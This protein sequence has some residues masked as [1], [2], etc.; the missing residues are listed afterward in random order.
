MSWLDL[1]SPRESSELKELKD[2]DEESLVASDILKSIKTSSIVTGNKRV[3]EEVNKVLKSGGTD[4]EK[5]KVI[6]NYL[7]QVKDITSLTYISSFR[8]EALKRLPYTSLKVNRDNN[9]IAKSNSALTKQ[10]ELQ[11]KKR[12]SFLNQLKYSPTQETGDQGYIKRGQG[13]TIGALG[14]AVAGA[15]KG[16]PIAGASIGGAIGSGAEIIDDVF[17]SKEGKSNEERFKSYL[18]Q[19][20]LA[21]QSRALDEQRFARESANTGRAKTNFKFRRAMRAAGAS[22]SA[23]REGF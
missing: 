9:N 21:N 7:N 20:Q 12:Q 3:S 15:F 4:Q 13:Q 19:K 8:K 22:A 18:E 6:E 14:G 2:Y 10:D 17:A 5:L 1:I 11:E 23:R 16:N